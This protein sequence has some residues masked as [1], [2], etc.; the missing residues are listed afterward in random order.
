LVR[1]IAVNK[2]ILITS[3]RMIGIIYEQ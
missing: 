1:H 3:N 2:R